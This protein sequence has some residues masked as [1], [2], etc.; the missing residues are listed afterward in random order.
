MEGSHLAAPSRASALPAVTASRSCLSCY[1]PSTA[2]SAS[3]T[4]GCVPWSSIGRGCVAFG[5]TS[6]TDTVALAYRRLPAGLAAEPQPPPPLLLAEALTRL[7]MLRSFSA[8]AAASWMARCSDSI[9]ACEPT[10][11]WPR[12]H[13]TFVVFGELTHVPVDLNAPACGNHA[14]SY[15]ARA[16]RTPSP[17]AGAT[18]WPT[19]MPSPPPRSPLAAAR[20]PPA[21]PC[22]RGSASPACTSRC[23]R[24]QPRTRVQ[25]VESVTS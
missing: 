25:R 17:S 14:P 15:R 7:V 19:C 6:T 18:R 21:A 13:E 10:V 23:T 11:T 12:R 5:R 16:R 2:P 9:V 4:A 20:A 8:D 3:R 24:S 22:A 1:T